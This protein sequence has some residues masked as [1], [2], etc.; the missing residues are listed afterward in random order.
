[1]GKLRKSLLKR[2]IMARVLVIDGDQ[3][4][5]LTMTMAI[6]HLGYEPCTI[7]HCEDVLQRVIDLQPDLIFIDIT[8]QLSASK[9]LCKELKEVGA[10]PN[11]PLI[12][13]STYP[14]H[15]RRIG[16]FGAVSFLGKPFDLEELIELLR[17][18]I[19][20]KVAG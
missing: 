17:K 10:L 6:R 14:A 4:I 12:V 20:E 15:A 2:I 13:F 11:V 5:L 7:D 9:K 16:E 18:Y 3:D 8:P 1:M 19:P